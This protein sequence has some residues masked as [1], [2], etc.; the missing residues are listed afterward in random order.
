MLLSLAFIICC[1]RNTDEEEKRSKVSSY[2]QTFEMNPAKGDTINKTDINGFKQGL[3][4]IYERNLNSHKMSIVEEGVYVNNQ[5]DGTWKY[6][7]SS[8]KLVR[9]V[10]FKNGQAW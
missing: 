9:L 8:E 1:Q 6:Y 4:V 7:D 5:K 2:A 10:K 3:W